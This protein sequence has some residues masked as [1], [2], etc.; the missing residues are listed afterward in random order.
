MKTTHTMRRC[1]TEER[2]RECMIAM[3]KASRGSRYGRR[4]YVIVDGPDNDFVVMHVDDAIK[5]EF[6]YRWEV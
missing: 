3:N 5:G 4:L 2:A 6:F 1:K